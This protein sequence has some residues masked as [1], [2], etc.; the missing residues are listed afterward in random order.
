MKIRREKDK[1]EH[2]Y[3]SMGGYIRVYPSTDW[4]KEKLYK[5]LLKSASTI[6]IMG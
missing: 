6:T 3:Q 5:A 1:L 4:A 2:E